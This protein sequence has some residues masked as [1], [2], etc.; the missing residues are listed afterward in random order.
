MC[1]IDVNNVC[2]HSQDTSN[3]AGSSTR[4]AG[5][6]RRQESILLAGKMEKRNF[7]HFG[8]KQL[9][10]KL[11]ASELGINRKH[12]RS[13]TDWNEKRCLCLSRCCEKRT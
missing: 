7:I 4:R 2:S 11:H 5:F 10:S 8:R 6:I 1:H 9:F 12:S 13:M 3:D